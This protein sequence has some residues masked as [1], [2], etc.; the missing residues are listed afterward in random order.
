MN[1]TDETNAD[2]PDRTA[3]SNSER[4]PP[5]TTPAIASARKRTPLTSAMGGGLNRWPQHA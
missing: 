1:R 2:Q 4:T 5:R 3:R